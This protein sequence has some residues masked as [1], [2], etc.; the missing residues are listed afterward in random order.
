MEG[1]IGLIVDASRQASRFLLRDYFELENLQGSSRKT[2]AYS[3]RSCMKILQVLQEK[4][5]KY[6]K[7]I[8]FDSKELTNLSFTDTAILVETIDGFANLTRSLPFFSIMITVLKIKNDQVIAEKSVMNFPILGEI[9][10]V[11]KGR[12]TWLERFNIN[13]PGALRL[14]VS[15]IDNIEEAIATTNFNTLE[16]AKILPNLRLY[17]SYTYSIA[18]LVSG[19][20]DVAIIR[21]SEISNLG[22]KLFIDEAV[23]A[24]HEQNQT[25]IASNIPL[26]DK[27]KHL[28]DKIGKI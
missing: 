25:I 14:R 15:G 16:I 27:I 1:E 28:V 13:F 19:K 10:Y 21:P 23:G 24:Y 18:Q 8:I 3:Q 9:Y 17:D 20:L 11:E 6:F 22:C 2:L 5:S 7:T 26:H 12:G 4:L